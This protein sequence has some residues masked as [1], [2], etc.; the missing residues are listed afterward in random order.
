MP[1]NF[2][3]PCAGKSKIKRKSKIRKM[4]RSRIRIKIKSRPLIA[5]GS[6][7]TLTLALT[8]LPNLTRTLD[9]D[10]D[11]PRHTS[12]VRLAIDA[13]VSLLYILISRND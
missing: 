11:L 4:I 2:G 7:P 10:L 12:G 8:H 13:A 1:L 6:S 3:V 5:L 9:L